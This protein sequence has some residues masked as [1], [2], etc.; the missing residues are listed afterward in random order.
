MQHPDQAAQRSDPLC[1]P[2][3][4]KSVGRPKDILAA[5]AGE[6]MA[7]GSKFYAGWRPR[8][9]SHV[10]DRF[11]GAGVVV[12]G[13]TNT[14]EFAL[15]PVTEPEAFGA[16]RNPW[17]LAHTAGGSSGGSAAAVASRMVPMASGGDGGG[18][19]RMPSSCC[20]LFG[21]KPTRGRVPTG[22]FEGDVWQGLSAEH[23]LTRSVRDSAAMLDATSGPDASEPALLPK[24]SRPFLEEARTEPGKLRIGYST[25]SP[26][27]GDIH[28][29]C[30]AAL[31]DAVSLLRSLGHELIE[32][33]LDINGTEWKRT[34]AALMCG[35]CAA[36]I[37]DAERSVGK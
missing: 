21:L 29:D 3:C 23:V 17:N 27:G 31:E 7:S 8:E 4:R 14:P 22:P 37:R 2:E 34:N 36:D 35:I 6:P 24:P 11:L 5:Y 12:L 19:I 9:N 32:A 26:I 20:G 25:T 33:K 10:V 28:A 18:S 15:L 1:S 30:R 13:K 16:T